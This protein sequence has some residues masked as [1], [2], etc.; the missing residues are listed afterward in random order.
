M[1][2][3]VS[4]ETSLSL[5]NNFVFESTGDNKGLLIPRNYVKVISLFQCKRLMTA[6]TALYQSRILC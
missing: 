5:G 6:L 3:Q 2:M 4:A 1:V